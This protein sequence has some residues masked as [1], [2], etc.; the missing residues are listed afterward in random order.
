MLPVTMIQAMPFRLGS[1]GQVAFP[2]TQ[3]PSLLAIGGPSFLPEMV[4]GVAEVFVDPGQP[5][6]VQFLGTGATGFSTPVPTWAD[7][8]GVKLVHQR[9]DL[10][11]GAIVPSNPVIGVVMP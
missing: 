3:A 8:I 2:P 7:L 1:T 4:G 9:F 5:L 6:A 10:M 11:S